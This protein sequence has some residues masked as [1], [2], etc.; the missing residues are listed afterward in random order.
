MSD[1]Q[2]SSSSSPDAVL[3]ITVPKGTDINLRV[4][5]TTEERSWRWSS[6]STTAANLLST[7]EFHDGTGDVDIW[8][9][10]GKSII[11]K[12]EET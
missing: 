5:S 9:R 10:A 7:S 2:S 6:S 11:L 3:T 12:L 1:N 4:A 8:L